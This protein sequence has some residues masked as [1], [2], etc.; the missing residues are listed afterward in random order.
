[1][2]GIIGLVVLIVLLAF[3]YELFSNI[4]KNISKKIYVL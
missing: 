4:T 2:E 1:M 3:N